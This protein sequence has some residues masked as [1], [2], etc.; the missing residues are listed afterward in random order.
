MQHLS[1][2]HVPEQNLPGADAARKRLCCATAGRCRALRAR[3]ADAAALKLNHSALAAECPTSVFVSGTTC[4]LNHHASTQ[5]HPADID[6]SKSVD[7]KDV[8]HLQAAVDTI[9]SLSRP[10]RDHHGPTHR[11]T[12][13]IYNPLFSGSSSVSCR[14]PAKAGG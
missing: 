12:D 9:S 7:T 4:T 3:S 2:A 14:S 11:T 5:T 13:K 10:R 1:C 8:V 6:R